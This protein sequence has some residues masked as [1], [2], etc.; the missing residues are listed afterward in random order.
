MEGAA[1]LTAAGQGAGAAAKAPPRHGRRLLFVVAWLV[2]FDQL[3]PPLLRHL[4][5]RRYEEGWEV[6]RFENSDLFALGPLVGYLRDNPR[7]ER[8][9][10]LFF[11]NSVVFGYGLEAADALPARY[12][13]RRPDV[14]VFSVA[15]NGFELPS[16]FL[17]ARAA[18]DAV[19]TMVVLVTGG[20]AHPRLPELVPV[21]EEDLHA[22]GLRRPGLEQRLQRGAEAWRLYAHRHR[23]QAA[24]F[25]A[26]TRQFLYL[27]KG[28][29][30]RRAM[31]AWR[32]PPP[33][34]APPPPPAGAVTLRAPHA[35]P[36]PSAARRHALREAYPLPWRFAELARAHG[37]RLVLLQLGASGGE[38]APADVPDFN[39]AFAPSA[40]VVLLGIDPALTLDGQHLSVP[41]AAA[42][43]D[44]L[45]RHE[46]AAETRR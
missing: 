45:A 42:L 46:R 4:E 6:F 22:F 10:V 36:G 27:H 7:G 16:N 25:G 15:V 37:K 35:D 41:G 44:A 21:A 38:V 29:L 8:P 40:E 5:R 3:V 14:R 2:V 17:V 20:A 32:E 9:R 34:G 24:L 1:G 26:S 28:E 31:G 23:L 33:R 19:D 30:A 18:V 11:G 39:A 13:E 43:A 12:Q